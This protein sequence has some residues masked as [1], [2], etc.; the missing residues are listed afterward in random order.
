[1]T[2]A[3]PGAEQ[4]GATMERLGR[5]ALAAAKALARAPRRVKDAALEAAAAALRCSRLTPLT[6]TQRARAAWG[7]RCSTGCC[8]MRSVSR[9]W[10]SASS[11]SRRC[12]TRSAR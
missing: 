10:R 3:T 6:W 4:L 7:R 1:M 8:S 2:H 12:R 5:E 11:R 9:R